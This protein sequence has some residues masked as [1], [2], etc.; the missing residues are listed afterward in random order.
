MKKHKITVTVDDR[1]KKAVRKLSQK[2]NIS[3]NEVAV[4]AIEAFL[5]STEFR[6]TMKYLL[7]KNKELYQRLG[8]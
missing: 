3:M 1:T 2:M 6:E 4:R 5:K 8:K 7:N